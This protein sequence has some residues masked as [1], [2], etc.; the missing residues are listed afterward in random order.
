MGAGAG[1][2]A[3]ANAGGRPS[4]VLSG[5]KDA[6]QEDVLP[7]EGEEESGVAFI[8]LA[9]RLGRVVCSGEACG[10]VGN[11]RAVGRKGV[12]LRA[13]SLLDL[14]EAQWEERAAWRVVTKVTA[15]HRL[16]TEVLPI[17]CSPPKACMRAGHWPCSS[18]SSSSSKQQQRQQQ[19]QHAPA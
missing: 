12:E 4:F 16:L 15:D 6:A 18:S 1:A 17:S 5:V 7:P 14:G 8:D 9:G 2:G 13:A 10:D 11:G 19:Q 3:G